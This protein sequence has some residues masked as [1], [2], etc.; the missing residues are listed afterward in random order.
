M[1]RWLRSS[2]VL[3]GFA[4]YTAPRRPRFTDVPTDKQFYRE[5][6]WLAEQGVTT[7]WPDIRPWAIAATLW[8]R[9]CTLQHGC[10]EEGKPCA[11]SRAQNL[12]PEIW[13]L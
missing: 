13:G 8:R 10:A 6:S 5:I 9:S 7:G 4:R 12:K 3:R 11:K 2:T 1:T